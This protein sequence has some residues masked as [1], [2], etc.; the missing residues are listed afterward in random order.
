MLYSRPMHEDP[1]VDARRHMEGQSTHDRLYWQAF[2]MLDSEF[3]QAIAASPHTMLFTPHDGN[4]ERCLSN[5]LKEMIEDGRLDAFAFISDMMRILAAVAAGN[6]SVQAQA[7]LVIDA[8]TRKFATNYADAMDAA[9]DL[10][11]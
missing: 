10:H 8:L 7:Q 1:L 11:E 6:E 3:R 9:G 5:V 2:K 4:E